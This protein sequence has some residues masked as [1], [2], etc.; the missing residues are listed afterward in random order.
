MEIEIHKVLSFSNIGQ[1][2]NQE[3]SFY[4]GKTEKGDYKPYFILCDGMG[5]HEKGEVASST[6]CEALSTY[7][8]AH[9]PKQGRVSEEYF[10]AALDYAYQKLHEKDNSADEKKM[11]T[12]LTCVY[13]SSDGAWCFHIGDSRIYHIRPADYNPKQ[14][15]TG[16]MFQTRDHSLVNSLLNAGELTEQEARNYKYK[17]I[18]TRAMQPKD[19]EHSKADYRLESDIRQGDFFFLCSDGVLEQLEN[20]ELCRILANAQTSDEEKLSEIENVCKRGTKDNHTCILLSIGTVKGAPSES[21]SAKDITQTSQAAANEAKEDDLSD[22]EPQ[23]TQS[24]A[25]DSL[26]GKS[27]KQTRK[28]QRPNKGGKS[29][30]CKAK[31]SPKRHKRALASVIVLIALALIVLAI[32]LFGK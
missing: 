19:G 3:D 16:L 4:V 9:P 23:K 6:V 22:I 7:F 31:S 29:A 10:N 18:I 13:L 11:G 27:K 17:N 25:E 1:R 15:A 5:G 32:R 28:S 21:L 12:T 2:A 24:K 20:E 8:D 30:A 26:K 14:H